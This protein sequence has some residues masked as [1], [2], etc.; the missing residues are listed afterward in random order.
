MV[1]CYPYLRSTLIY[2]EEE[3][4]RKR[5]HVVHVSLVLGILSIL[6]RAYDDDEGLIVWLR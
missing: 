2:H 3:T 4:K 5:L 6:G 1:R